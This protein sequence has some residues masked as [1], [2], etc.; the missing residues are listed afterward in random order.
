MKNFIKERLKASLLKESI[1]GGYYTVFH[2]SKHKI[3][4]FTDDFVGGENATDQE[5]PGIYFTT[6]REEANAYGEF[7]YTVT[8]TPKL[9][10]DTTPT[11]SSK[12]RPLLTKM[13]KMAKDWQDKAQNFDE[14][15]LKG[16]S[17]FVESALDYNDTEKDVVQQVWIDFYKYEPT[18]YVRNM[19]KLG[20]DGLIVPRYSKDGN[21]IIVYNPSIIKL[22]N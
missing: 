9:L 19:T 8:L 2:G 10:L 5:G 1:K 3:T 14:N 12:L 6:S 16:I 11:N 20:I 15:P 13:A 7:I 21:H 22:Q 4:N 18:D 17:V